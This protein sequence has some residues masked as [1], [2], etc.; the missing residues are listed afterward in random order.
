MREN[1]EFL[2]N[3]TARVEPPS[4]TGE[5][6]IIFNDTLFL[7]GITYSD[8]NSSNTEIVILPY[9]ELGSSLVTN[10]SKF[11]LTWESIALTKNK[12]SI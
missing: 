8:I 2:L 5:M 11:N 10:L 1:Y 3:I 12:L 9:I 6:D 4:V 7:E